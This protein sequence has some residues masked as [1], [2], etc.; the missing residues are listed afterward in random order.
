MAA[1][2]G[3][4]FDLVAGEIV[5]AHEAAGLLHALDEQVA[6]RPTVQRL[7]ALLRDES[8]RLGVLRLHQPLAR[9]QRRAIGQEQRGGELVLRQVGAG[10]LD[11]VREIGRHR[12]AAGG[13][14]DGGR[15]HVG[16]AHRAEALQRQAPGAQRARRRDRLRPDQ[17]LLA[18]DVVD[19]GRG[20]GHR[21]VH[22]GMAHLR[23]GAHAV[24]DA[25]AAVGQAD[26]A[27]RAA[28][29]PDHHRLDHGQRELHG[30]GRVDRIAPGR[31]HFEA[32]GGGQRMVGDRHARRPVRRLF[33]AGELRARALAP[34]RLGHPCPRKSVVRNL[35]CGSA[36]GYRPIVP[37]GAQRSVVPL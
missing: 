33:L 2:R 19:F 12:K 28:D 18:L 30:H 21:L 1:D 8:Q 17:V 27:G 23:H 16:Q 20:A 22:V 25:M 31:E 3:A 11:A 13:V 34:C 6:Q 10:I 7:L 36:G 29:Q 9:L 26:V 5:A 15:H 4:L 35:A 32:G 24:E 37:S 14:A